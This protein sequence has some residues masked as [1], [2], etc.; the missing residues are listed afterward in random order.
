[1]FYSV[2]ANY[3]IFG[4]AGPNPIFWDPIIFCISFGS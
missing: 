2:I 4:G 1:M 3:L